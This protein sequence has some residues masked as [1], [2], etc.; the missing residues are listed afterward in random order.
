MGLGFGL[1]FPSLA[2]LVVLVQILVAPKSPKLVPVALVPNLVVPAVPEIQTLA[3]PV[4]PVPNLVV[5]AFLVPSLADLAVLVVPSLVLPNSFGYVY[6]IGKGIQNLHQTKST[7]LLLSLFSK[8]KCEEEWKGT[9]F[10]I[11]TEKSGMTIEEG[12]VKSSI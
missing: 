1:D 3:D 4:V 2:G 9:V 10:L 12:Q 8:R 5:L 6:K 7:K 11:N